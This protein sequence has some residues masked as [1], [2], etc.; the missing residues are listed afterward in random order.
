[1]S[2]AALSGAPRS[3]R[4]PLL[5]GPPSRLWVLAR[6]AASDAA[7]NAVIGRRQIYILPTAFGGIFGGGLFLLFLGSLNYL[8]NLGLLFTFLLSALGLIAMLHTWRNL[9]GLRL[10]ISEGRAVFAGEPAS[11]PVQIADPRGRER[12]GLALVAG[13]RRIPF[14]VGA[15]TPKNLDLLVPTRRRGHHGLGRIRVETLYPMA[16]FRAWSYLESP[17]RVLVYPS[18]AA[19]APEAVREASGAEPAGSGNSGLGVDDF[20]GLRAYRPGDA[21]SRLHWKA[22]AR[23]GGLFVKQF[24]GEHAEALWIGWDRLV[25]ADPELRLSLMCRQIIDADSRGVRYGLRL[26][27]RTLEPGSGTEHRRRCLSALALCTPDVTG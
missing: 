14:E 22:M 15:G 25:A 13:E 19:A 26:P 7:G 9:L 17:A 5:L 10:R 16:L 18:P 1:V 11:F 27:G 12:P 20:L 3:S 21:L 4:N 8:N 24:G 6:V 2:A 23:G